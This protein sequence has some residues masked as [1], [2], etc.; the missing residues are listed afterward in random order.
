MVCSM[1]VSA[2]N[3]PRLPASQERTSA[4][5]H[6]HTLAAAL[7]ERALTSL[8]LAEAFRQGMEAFDRHVGIGRAALFLVT[9]TSS[10]LR[11][12]AT[13]GVADDQFLPKFG[14]GVAGRVCQNGRP[15]V[16]PAVRQ[17][18][19]ALS[20]LADPVEWAELP[21][22]LVAL[23]VRSNN[24]LVGTISAYFRSPAA[25]GFSDRIRAVTL[26]TELIAGALGTKPKPQPDEAKPEAPV[27][28]RSRTVFE[29][30][31]MI[32]ASPAMRQIY[33]QI[34]QVARTNATALLRGESGTGK[35]LVAQAIHANSPR[36]NAPF[37]K[38]NCAA[39]PESLFESELFGHERGAFTGAHSRRK[40]R[41]ELAE[42]GTLFLD[43]IGEITL[44]TQ[45]KLLRVLQS[46]EF[47]RLGGTETLHTDVRIV[48]ATNKDMEKAVAE[49][50][51]REDLYYRLNVFSI[52]LPSLRNR[53]ADIPALAE[54][55]LG[56]YAVEH[57][58]A[59][60]RL[61]SGAIDLLCQ[62]DWPG[63]VRELENVIERAVVVCDGSVIREQHFPENLKA[64]E[65]TPTRQ[66]SL[67][68]AVANLE[69][70]LI[71]EALS[72]ERGNVARAAR[73]LGTS[74]RVIRY[75]AG[76]YEIDTGSFR[77]Q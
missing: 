67:G 55:F 48:T 13:Y 58:C 3:M 70:R 74:E 7:L 30:S 65:V 25:T 57:A 43:E 22:C 60:T 6:P 39:L 72:K 51:F 33:E 18:P 28:V 40:G 32:G 71:T 68:E 52:T 16:I 8:E 23:P 2:A 61:S 66:L 37:V 62:Y 34:G 47:E 11:V 21:W 77:N 54:Y 38:V 1:P 27:P 5:S 36:A 24:A 59:V 29:Y 50:S 56:K 17:D 64:S 12:T 19:M 69:R 76:K 31:N 45:A 14:E 73:A 41:F 53:R 46:R 10:E 4:N 20:E 9:P 42:G 49:G 26:V 15:M 63:N 44:T 35:E 75:K